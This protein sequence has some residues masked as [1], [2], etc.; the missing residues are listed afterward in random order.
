MFLLFLE[1]CEM[2]LIVGIVSKMNDYRPAFLDDTIKIPAD[3]T[4]AMQLKLNWMKKKTN[5]NLKKVNICEYT[6][7]FSF[8]ISFFK[9]R[10]F[11]NF[12]FLFY[13]LFFTA[14]L[15]RHQGGFFFISFIRL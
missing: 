4:T 14:C 2:C 11:N 1:M 3:R 12:I 5:I 7:T 13:F 8:N 6:L 10:K 9:R 15:M